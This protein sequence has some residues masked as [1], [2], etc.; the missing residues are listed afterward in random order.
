MQS[1][2][3]SN[4][5]GIDVSNWQRDIDFSRVKASGI[6]IVYIKATEGTTFIDYKARENYQGAK[7]NGLMV[8]FY[9]FFRARSEDNAKAQANFFIE[10]I[11]DLEP[12]CKYALDIETTEGLDKTTLSRLAKIFVDEVYRIT[13]K[14]CIL[15]T[16]SNFIEESL[17]EVLKDIPLWV[18]SYGVGAPG[19][20]SIWNSWTGFQYSSSGK[21][22]GIEGNVDLNE[23]TKDVLLSSKVI[24]DTPNID[25]VR[26]IQF[27]INNRYSLN[28]SVDNVFGPETLK[29]IVSGIQIELNKQYGAQLFVDGIV[30]PKTLGALVTLRN[31]ASGNITWLM[32][33]LLICRGYSLNSHGVDGSFGTETENAVKTFQRSNGLLVDGIVGAETWRKLLTS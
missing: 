23:F 29:A 22:D 30:G 14:A 31:G 3:A 13:G 1:R 12:D 9:H 17:T 26:E 28:I 11:K 25:S 2:N 33:A 24:I 4:L 5:R 6:Q 20:N 15:Y 21:I 32:Q 8:G 16:Y 19:N 27:I 18:A 10:S 7:S